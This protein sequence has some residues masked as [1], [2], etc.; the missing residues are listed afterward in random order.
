MRATRTVSTSAVAVDEGH[1]S[2]TSGQSSSDDHTGE[3]GLPTDRLTQSAT[4]VPSLSPVPSSVCTTLADLNWHRIMEEEF[5]AL[6]VNNTLDL[7]SC[8]VGSNVVTDK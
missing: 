5:A 2:G 1:T 6:I 4:S 3:A 8:P 7:V